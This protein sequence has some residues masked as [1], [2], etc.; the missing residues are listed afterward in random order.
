MKRTTTVT[1]TT[2]YTDVAAGLRTLAD[3]LERLNGLPA[4]RH[5]NLPLDIGISL[6]SA[7]DVALAA[8]AFGVEVTHNGPWQ[9]YAEVP[10]GGVQARF[11]H[12]SDAGM[13]DWHAK[14]ALVAT[15]P[16]SS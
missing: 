13:A 1:R 6:N 10:I 16:V 9:T 11:T 3:S 8:V 14:M 12:V 5:P 7:N 2:T 4:R 15:L